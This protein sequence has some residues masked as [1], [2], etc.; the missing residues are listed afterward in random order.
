MELSYSTQAWTARIRQPVPLALS[1]I[2]GDAVH[3]LRAS[4]DLALCDLVRLNE[5]SIDGVLFPFCRSAADLPGMIKRRNV[6]RAGKDVVEL[7]HSMRP[8]QSGYEGLRAIH[9]MDVADKHQTLLPVLGAAT[10]PLAKLLG[11]S[12]PAEIA[13][14]ST[15]ISKDGQMVIGLPGSMGIPLGTELPARFFLAFGNGRGFGGKSVFE[16]LHYLAQV[17]DGVVKA[18]AA[19]RPGAAFPVPDARPARSK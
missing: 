4:L 8:Y 16:F 10:L 15:L 18:L 13:N 9:D 11:R 2:I 14:F 3:N 17:A 6:H 7:I 19:L 12:I 1:P 5:R